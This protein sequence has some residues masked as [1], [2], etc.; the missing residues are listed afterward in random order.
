MAYTKIYTRIDWKNE[1]ESKTTPLGAANL[2][3][4]DNAINELDNRAIEMDL[5]K[6]DKTEA[7][8]LIKDWTVD[9]NTGVI[10]ITKVDGSNMV[11][12]LNIE[13]V[14][15][16]FELTPDGVLKMTTDDGQV[17][18]ANI[19]AMIPVISFKE[20]DTIGY[21]VVDGA[22]GKE[23]TFSVKDSSI[24]SNKLVP[25]YLSDLTVLSDEARLSAQESKRYSQESQT[26][27]E[28]SKKSSDSSEIAKINAEQSSARAEQLVMQAYD[29]IKNSG[30]MNDI[31]EILEYASNEFKP[32]T[33]LDNDIIGIGK[34]YN[35]GDIF[36]YAIEGNEN[37]H[38]RIPGS[39]DWNITSLQEKGFIN[40]TYELKIMK[41]S[42]RGLYIIGYSTDASDIGRPFIYL[43][44]DGGTEEFCYLETN[45]P[46][47]STY[48]DFI[49][50]AESYDEIILLSKD[51]SL[52]LSQSVMA[53]E[54]NTFTFIDPD[55]NSV[56]NSIAY[57]N[58]IY[59][60][61]GKGINNAGI[62]CVMRYT[63]YNMSV[64]FKGYVFTSNLVKV[65][66]VNGCFFAFSEDG[67]VCKTENGTQWIEVYS[68]DKKD[69]TL[70]SPISIAYNG[71]ELVALMPDYKIY[72]S[73]DGSYWRVI[74]ENSEYRCLY[75]D[76]SGNVLAGTVKQGIRSLT[77]KTNSFSLTNTVKELYYENIAKKDKVFFFTSTFPSS[78]STQNIVF[79]D[80]RLIKGKYHFSISLTTP[81]SDDKYRI[82][83][84]DGM[85]QLSLLNESTQDITAIIRIELI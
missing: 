75:G 26:S 18:T 37:I 42:S 40:G 16:D 48:N 28:A 17:F 2:N 9:V 59:V 76:G 53:D 77:G 29:I 84:T 38:W 23:Y 63:S 49:E 33:A 41:E 69:A 74:S 35:I 30:N 32:Q 20:S 25:N 64:T 7:N 10:T 67:K 15:V 19:A 46:T 62:A 31:L 50:V 65:V 34:L 8:S 79:R 44:V 66:Y 81:L 83:T 22:Q 54:A 14:P 58:G 36:Y 6:F 24:S 78:R 85:L 13:K 56:F 21:S 3:K 5:I 55:G 70:F 52:F 43:Y 71:K 68:F 57:G 73:E 61:V 1:N 60:A 47:Y 39:D 72:A 51:G 80:A 45:V 4:M 12:D 82:F 27:S 11:F